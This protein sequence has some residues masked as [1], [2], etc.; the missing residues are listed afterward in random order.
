MAGWQHGMTEDARL[1][2][3]D[4]AKIA[5]SVTEALIE[6]SYDLGGRL[7]R[8][9]HPAT[10]TA[11]AEDIAQL[12]GVAAVWVRQHAAGLG[13]IRIGTGPRPRHRFNPATAVERMARMG[14]APAQAAKPEP[15]QR[16][17]RRTKRGG[18]VDLIAIKRPLIA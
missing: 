10:F 1:H 11:T 7:E 17:R 6:R 16:P 14:G 2:P 8:A 13:G 4:L 5:L 3:D 9:P 15:K 18:S 12:C